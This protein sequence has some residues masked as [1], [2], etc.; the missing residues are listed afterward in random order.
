MM[1]D[2]VTYDRILLLDLYPNAD[3]PH[4][5]CVSFANTGIPVE[6]LENLKMTKEARLQTRFLP[7]YPE[8]GHEYYVVAKVETEC[9]R[10]EEA[11]AAS[12]VNNFIQEHLRAGIR[13]QDMV[14]HVVDN[15]RGRVQRLVPYVR[16]A[17]RGEYKLVVS[18]SR[19]RPAVSSSDMDAGEARTG[20]Q[21]FDL[22]KVVKK[23]VKEC[24]SRPKAIVDAPRVDPTFSDADVAAALASPIIIDSNVTVPSGL[25]VAG[26]G[27]KRAQLNMSSVSA[28]AAH[29]QGDETMPPGN[30]DNVKSAELPS[31]NIQQ[32]PGTG[33][34][35]A[36]HSSSVSMSSVDVQ[37]G[38]AKA[39]AP[40][41]E[42]LHSLNAKVDRNHAKVA[43]GL[44]IAV[45]L[46]DNVTKEVGEIRSA[47]RS[48]A[49]SSAVS[50]VKHLESVFPLRSTIEVNTYLTD[51]PDTSLAM[52]K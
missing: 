44:K 31:G 30:L 23:T 17:E 28:A 20:R 19:K 49:G 8:P 12:N 42:R 2:R 16:K 29:S 24:A 13:I 40:L 48:L 11:R 35:P 36:R 1:T 26:D 46:M 10:S 6:Q 50:S 45:K 41:L 4:V 37:S 33:N 5:T 15:F 21:M 38:I 51:D 52:Q 9:Y 14:P 25:S 27:G 3:Y 39:V 43:E 47:V 18:S 32:S 22:R 34:S 7:I